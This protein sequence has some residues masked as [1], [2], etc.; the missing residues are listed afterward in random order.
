VP[1]SPPADF[2]IQRIG[3]SAGGS[4]DVHYRFVIDMITA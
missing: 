4:K 3:I 2:V 1:G